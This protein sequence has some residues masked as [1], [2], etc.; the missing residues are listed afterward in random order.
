MPGDFA[1]KGKALNVIQQMFVPWRAEYLSGSC[2]VSGTSRY[3]EG[4]LFWIERKVCYSKAWKPRKHKIHND[5]VPIVY[6]TSR[7]RKHKK[8]H[9]RRRR[10]SQFLYNNTGNEV[11]DWLMVPT[12][13]PPESFRLTRHARQVRRGLGEAV[14]C[15]G[16]GIKT[17]SL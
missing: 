10:L 16:D 14:Q 9:K 4:S 6:K 7:S 8:P 1:Y 17:R 5:I 3:S 13:I 11:S 15:W 2:V 12:P